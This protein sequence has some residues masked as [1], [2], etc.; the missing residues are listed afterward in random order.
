[1]VTSDVLFFWKFISK[2]RNEQ[3]KTTPHRR[4]WEILISESGPLDSMD[5]STA[6]ALFPWAKDS[7]EDV[8]PKRDS[9]AFDYLLT[10]WY[11]SMLWREKNSCQTASP[12]AP[13]YMVER[14]WKLFTKTRLPNL[15]AANG[16]T[17]EKGSQHWCSIPADLLDPIRSTPRQLWGG[18]AGIL[19]GHPWHR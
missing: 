2:W 19:D 18:C 17:W 14:C 9:E 1:M 16:F 12:T 5:Q 3:R 13:P 8:L 10:D 11:V 4:T 15:I 7:Q 6:T